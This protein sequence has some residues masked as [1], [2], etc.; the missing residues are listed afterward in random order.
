VIQVRDRMSRTREGR[1]SHPQRGRMSHAKK[2]DVAYSRRQDVT[3]KRGRMSLYTFVHIKTPSPCLPYHCLVVAR[4]LVIGLH[5][6]GLYGGAGDGARTR[7]SLLGRQE[8]TGLSL[9]WYRSAVGADRTSVC[10]YYAA[11][12]K[13][14]ANP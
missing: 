12:T 7:D 5:R 6:D 11:L 8:V 9:A 3:P 10:V 1:V 14:V 2:Q 4:R 13:D